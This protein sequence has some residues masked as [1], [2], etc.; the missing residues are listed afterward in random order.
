MRKTAQGILLELENS[1]QHFHQ[2]LDKSNW[3]RAIDSALQNSIKQL[4]ELEDSA[5]GQD[6]ANLTRE[7]ELLK[8]NAAREA[9]QEVVDQDKGGDAGVMQVLLSAQFDLI[10]SLNDLL[11]MDQDE[12][13][14]HAKTI[15]GR[16]LKTSSAAAAHVVKPDGTLNITEAFPPTKKG[17]P[18]RKKHSI[19]LEPQTRP[20]PPTPTLAPAFL[21]ETHNF[22]SPMKSSPKRRKAAV[23]KKNVSFTPKKKSPSK[24]SVRWRD[25]ADSGALAEFEK[26]PQKAK[27]SPEASSAEPAMLPPP[28]PSYLQADVST[29]SLGSSPVPD[30]PEPSIDIKPKANR[31]QAGFLSRK[32]GVSPPPPTITNLSSSD[33]DN[34]PLRAIDGGNRVNRSSLRISQMAGGDSTPTDSGNNSSSENENW[35]ADRSESTK[36]GLALK[37]AGSVSR[38][39]LHGYSM[40]DSTGR[41]QRRRSP[42]AASVSSSPPNENNLFTASHA[43]R[44][45]TSQKEPMFS[46]SVLAPRT[47]PVMKSG[48]RRTTIGDGRQVGSMNSQAIRLSGTGTGS[49]VPRPRESVAGVMGKGGWR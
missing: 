17:T 21:P 43:R 23:G 42:T 48:I 32:S 49:A 29:G 40:S 5:D 10:S 39:S 38:Q 9:L 47:T 12:A 37:R 25:D 41:T 28:L 45:V 27:E 44:M 34:S 14:H 1:R 24:R 33:T 31:F 15:L 8:A 3:E 6:V 20:A 4:I 16:L 13:I 2:K 35:Q 7:V 18:K 19:S 22:S 36:I 30:A 11:S 46:S 26:T